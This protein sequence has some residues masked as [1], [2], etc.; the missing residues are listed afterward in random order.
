MQAAEEKDIKGFLDC[1]SKLSIWHTCG[2]CAEA[3]PSSLFMNKEYHITDDIFDSLIGPDD[4][5]VLLYPE[6]DGCYVHVCKECNR[7][8]KKQ[9]VPPCAILNGFE[10][11]DIPIVLSRLN[12]IEKKMISRVVPFVKITAAKG[13][14]YSHQGHAVSYRNRFCAVAH[15]LPRHPRDC[16]ELHVAFPDENNSFSGNK[17]SV[18]PRYLREALEWLI[19]NNH[20]YRDVR[21]NEDLLVILEEPFEL[22]E[23]DIAV[24]PDLPRSS[25]SGSGEAEEQFVDGELPCVNTL[26][27]NLE[28]DFQNTS[29][30][31]HLTELL[32]KQG[33]TD[34]APSTP[35]ACANN[36]VEGNFFS[37]F[38]SV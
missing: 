18:Q 20:L 14:Q 31:Q 13:G 19:E 1:M 25:V 23:V 11:G 26:V 8:L 35:V 27:H 2:V 32:P 24:V 15:I 6:D 22:P 29:L 34:V 28:D 3:N 4:N 38:A 7:Y 17:Y 16:M 5:P 37:H 30:Q 21:I 36:T 12:S 10:F 33:T 9:K